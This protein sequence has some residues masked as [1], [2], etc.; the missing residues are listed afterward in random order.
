MMFPVKPPSPPMPGT[1][2]ALVPTD[3]VATQENVSPRP[4]YDLHPLTVDSLEHYLNQAD[5]GERF[6]IR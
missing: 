2:T 3:S 5:P 4:D 1:I 6:H